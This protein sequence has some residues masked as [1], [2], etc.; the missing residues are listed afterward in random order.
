MKKLD[1]RVLNVNLAAVRLH[2]HNQVTAGL[3]AF[4]CPLGVLLNMD[5]Q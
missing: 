1:M 5:F 3:L 4:H 2:L